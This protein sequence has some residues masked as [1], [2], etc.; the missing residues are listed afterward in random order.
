MDLGLKGK[1][2]VVTAGARGIGAGICRV[3][4][5]EG[6]NV[7]INYR[8]KPEE[9]CEFAHSLEKEYGIKALAVQGDIGYEESITNLFRRAIDTFGQVDCVVNNAGVVGKYNLMEEYDVE[10]FR[11]YER[12]TIEGAMLTSRELVRFCKEN[13]R[14]GHIV[15]VLSKSAF[16]SSSI[17]NTNYIT[18]KG[19]LAALTVGLAHEVAR[20][21]IFVNAIIPGYVKNSTYKPDSP[22]TIEKRKLIPCGD[23][24][25]PEDMGYVTAFLCSERASSMNGVIVDCTQ[26]TLAGSY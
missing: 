8:S 5:Q 1:V 15:N 23:F 13:G 3:F 6:A 10:K 14:S 17:G 4:A 22:R 9:S 12:V 16:F 21:N 19:A 24:A 11:E 20:H 26:G 2:A 25:E 7:V 18:S